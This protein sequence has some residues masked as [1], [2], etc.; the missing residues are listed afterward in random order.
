MNTP[1][2][3][4]ELLEQARNERRALWDAIVAEN[5]EAGNDAPDNIDEI[6]ALYADLRID[7]ARAQEAVDAGGSLDGIEVDPRPEDAPEGSFTVLNAY[8]VHF[9]R[10]IDET[11]RVN[12]LTE[13]D[14]SNQEHSDLFNEA[15][16]KMFEAGESINPLL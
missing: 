5:I 1:Q 2:D 9:R 12:N 16:I 6:G 3:W 15:E 4:T 11:I 8:F 7:F 10:V 14:L 13:F